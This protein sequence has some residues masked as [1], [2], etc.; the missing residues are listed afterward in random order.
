MGIFRKIREKFHDDWCSV[1]TSE[2][3]VIYRQLYALPTMT[4]GHYISHD[5]PE[6]YKAHLVPVS[7]KAEIPTG[8]YACGIKAYRCPNCGHRAVKLSVF[9]PVRD[10]EK[11]EQNLYFEKGEMDDFIWSADQVKSPLKQ[12]AYS[13]MG[14]ESVVRGP[15]NR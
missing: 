1:C 3:E 9:L 14:G 13:V 11:A 2:M 7:R 12:K 8:M 10:I 15:Y 6:Y 5:E 4:V